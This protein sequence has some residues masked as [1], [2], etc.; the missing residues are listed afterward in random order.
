MLSVP[1]YSGFRRSNV[2]VDL[3]SEDIAAKEKDRTTKFGRAA[4]S[5]VYGS[6]PEAVGAVPQSLNG[7]MGR[8][9]KPADYK[10]ERAK[11]MD[12]RQPMDK[13]FIHRSMHRY[14]NGAGTCVVRDCVCT[15]NVRGWSSTA[16]CR[17]FC[18]VCSPFSP[19]PLLQHHVSRLHG[20]RV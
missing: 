14:G 13:T 2:D 3:L 16:V 11:R 6:K 15:A 10:V 7:T 12:H 19:C 9:L 20:C 8:G 17:V 18:C 4:A 1:G 5:V